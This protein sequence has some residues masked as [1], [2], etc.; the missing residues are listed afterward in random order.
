LSSLDNNRPSHRS[1]RRK[2]VEESASDDEVLEGVE[3]VTTSEAEATSNAGGASDMVG[4]DL[5]GA[6]EDAEAPREAEEEVAE[7]GHAP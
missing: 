3:E 6:T 5:D 7:N 2:T 4:H 1:K